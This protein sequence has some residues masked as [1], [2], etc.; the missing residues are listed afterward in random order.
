LLTSLDWTSYT[1]GAIAAIVSAVAVEAVRRRAG[2]LGLLDLP[3]SRSTHRVP[4]PR[5]GGIGILVGTIAGI[6]AAGVLSGHRLGA[7]A[8]VLL[9][10]SLA[11]G[12]V[13]LIDDRRSLSPALRLCVQLAAGGVLVAATGPIPLFS[14][15]APAATPPARDWAGMMIAVVW[16]TTVTNFFNFMDGIDGLAGGQTV[17][18]CAGIA[19]AG[20]SADASVVAVMLASASAGFLLHNWPPARIFMGDVGSY[21]IGFLLAGLPLLAPRENRWTAVLAV[22]IGMTFFILDPVLALCRR[23]ARGEPLMQAHR[24]HFYQKLVPVGAIERRVPL[25]IT[26][27]AVVLSIAGAVAF[28]NGRLIWMAVAM[29]FLLFSVEAFSASRA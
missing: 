16:L 14:A 29:A 28:H 9:G 4:I 13:G 24:E 20:W 2:S 5:G 3:G 6:T 23:A 15:S 10:C 18:S 17:A 27:G 21:A 12:G 22:A 19:L 26:L 25:L 8:L 11:L 1:A 7:D